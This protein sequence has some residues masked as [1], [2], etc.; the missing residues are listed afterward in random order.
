MSQL[1]H[2]IISL[3]V[4][5]PDGRLIMSNITATPT[6][7]YDTSLG[8]LLIQLNNSLKQTLRIIGLEAVD[9]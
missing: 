1:K 4:E 9:S 5:T 6:G 3:A 8:S 7:S 2:Y